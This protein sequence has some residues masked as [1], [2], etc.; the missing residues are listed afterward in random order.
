MSRS[1][2]ITGSISPSSVAGVLLVAAAGAAYVIDTSARAKAAALRDATARDEQARFEA[3]KAAARA[4]QA[5]SATISGGR[6]RI[7]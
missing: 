7:V 2:F 3:Q 1:N 6:W 4:A 5:K